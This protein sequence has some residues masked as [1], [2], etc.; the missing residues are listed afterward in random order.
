MP[1]CEGLLAV[2]C[3]FILSMVLETMI[4]NEIARKIEDF[5]ELGFPQ[6]FPRETEL[7]MVDNMVSTVIGSRRAGKSFRVLQA[8][9]EMIQKKTINSIKHVC[10]LDFDNPILAGLNVTD[11]PIIQDTFIKLNPEIDIKTPLLFVF[12][13]I[14]KIDGW[15]QYVISLSGNPHWK[16]IITGSSS[17]LLKTD[18]VTELRGKAIS[19]TIYPLSFKEYLKFKGLNSLSASTQNR[20]KIRRYFDEYLSWG[21]FPAITDLSEQLKEAVLREYFDTMILK[22]IIQRYDISK[23]RMCIHLYS[24]LMSNISKP[25]TLKS[26]HGYLNQS[27][28]RSSKDTIR[29]YIH[30]AE[31]SWLLFSIPIYSDS[32]KEQERNYRKLYGI[33]WGLAMKNSTIWDGYLSRAMEN[34]VFLHLRQ[35]FHRVNYYLTKK[36]RQEVDF[37]AVNNKGQPELAVQVCMDISD[38]N[39]LKREVESLTTTAEYFNIKEKLII[40]YNQDRTIQSKNVTIRVLPAWKWLLELD[41]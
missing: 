41:Y 25:Y 29:D 2:I 3:D 20:A 36:N 33:D 5:R 31:D 37:I 1:F 19:T 10:C 35:N 38:E 8:A 9:K 26:V 16:V 34:M 17:K 15:E 24:Y 12:D 18:I 28:L 14:H 4:E 11:L 32:L 27:G 40:T 23:P 30:R 6:Y 21:G 39:T 7:L 22:D 13:E